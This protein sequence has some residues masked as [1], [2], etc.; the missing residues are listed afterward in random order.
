MSLRILSLFFVI[1]ISVCLS[2]QHC[3][4]DHAHLQKIKTNPDFK[5]NRDKI[6]SAISE[7]T[8][9]ELRGDTIV[10]PVVFHIYHNGDALGIQE[11]ITD[12][13]ILAQLD[14]INKDFRR[15]NDDASM[16]PAA[17]Q[18][19]AADTKIEFCLAELDPDGIETTGILR[20]HIN[21]LSNVSESDCWTT[22]YI[23]Q[24]FVSP[25][26]WDRDFYLNIYSILSIDNFANGNCEF[27]AS[28]GYGQF[29]GG[30]ASTD[31]VV[32]AFFTIG[33]EGMPNP[34]QPQFN[35]RTATHEIGHWLDL[36]HPWGSSAGSCNLDDDVSDTPAQFSPDF[37]CPAF[38]V[39]DNCTSTGDGILFSN[40]MQWYDDDCLNM[41]T[42]GQSDRMRALIEV[43]RPSLLESA[44]G[45]GVLS[46]DNNYELRAYDNDREHIIEWTIS[47]IENTS[48][49]ILEYG[50]SIDAFSNLTNEIIDPKTDQKSFIYNHN[51]PG[52][53]I[54]YYRLKVSRLNG[55]LDYSEIISLTNNV[56]GPILKTNPVHNLLELS[57]SDTNIISYK[58]LDI[59]GKVIA[60]NLSLDKAISIDVSTFNDGVYILQL[61]T[62]QG[63]HTIK[64]IKA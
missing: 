24:N 7:Y 28:L 38:P 42:T 21:T 60:Q 20:N 6:K 63:S 58:I 15:N 52:V 43:A 36:E 1:H 57:S 56:Q 5:D 37:G 27:F 30:P 9:K 33:S 62:D 50:R 34:L 19:L 41:F 64:W 14:Q 26:I 45:A 47:D 17:F 44:C 55:D 59:S 29:P 25:T 53:G 40:F 61:H 23:D 49:V 3:S 8:S 18:G 4:T 48:E 10:I 22:D 2:A 13:L 35:G 16:T 54:H 32:L 12:E 51:N 11:N 39:F 31:A 46:I